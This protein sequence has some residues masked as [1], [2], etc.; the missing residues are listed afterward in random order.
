MTDPIEIDP[1]QMSDPVDPWFAGIPNINPEDP[2]PSPDQRT[3]DEFNREIKDVEKNLASLA[4]NN[5]TLVHSAAVVFKELRYY[6]AVRLRQYALDTFRKL[7]SI[8]GETP[9]VPMVVKENIPPESQL[10]FPIMIDPNEITTKVTVSIYHDAPQL[11][12]AFTLDFRS[13][14]SA[15]FSNRIKYR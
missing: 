5:L 10:A 14:K 12:V 2:P 3:G 7:V 11:E 9:Q 4:N 15:T 8:I 13:G 1:S 6:D